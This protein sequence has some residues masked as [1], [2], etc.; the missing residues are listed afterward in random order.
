MT[1]LPPYVR[2]TL[3]VPVLSDER[4]PDDWDWTTLCRSE[5]PIHCPGRAEPVD[6]DDPD[7]DAVRDILDPD[8]LFERE[9]EHD[10]GEDGEHPFCHACGADGAG[11]FATS[12]CRGF[13]PAHG[14]RTAESE[15]R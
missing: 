13:Q 11:G 4:S 15:A 9:R 8:R 6:P 10:F 12:P 1:G 5:L 2:V 7:L 14:P 3:L